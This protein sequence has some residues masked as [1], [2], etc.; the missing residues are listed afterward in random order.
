MS[1]RKRQDD[2]REWSRRLLDKSTVRGEVE[3]ILKNKDHPSFSA[4]WAR[5]A[6]FAHGKPKQ[7]VEV[8]IPQGL[9]IRVVRE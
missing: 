7:P 3:G 9:T 5:L 2:F 4:M 8:D 1:G 6:D